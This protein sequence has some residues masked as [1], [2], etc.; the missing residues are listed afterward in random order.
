MGTFEFSSHESFPED[1]YIA[2]AVVL[3]IDGKH[4]VT[5]V[6]KKMKNGGMFWDVI[7]ASVMQHGEKK[8][9]K[10]YSQDSKFLEDDIKNFL[11]SRNW[12]KGKK[13]EKNDQMPF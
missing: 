4:R 10:A 13:S 7:S 6:R 11:E 9:L 3:V 8:F 12:G 2:E 5:Y 1:Q